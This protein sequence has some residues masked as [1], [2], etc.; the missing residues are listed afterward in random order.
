MMSQ[1]LRRLLWRKPK[2]LRLPRREQRMP[3]KR[4][5]STAI[6]MRLPSALRRWKASQ[7]TRLG[8]DATDVQSRRPRHARNC[9]RRGAA[10]DGRTRG[11]LSS[12]VGRGEV[13][14]RGRDS[15]G[16]A[17]S[18]RRR[19]GAE[20]RSARPRIHGA[21]AVPVASI[22]DAAHGGSLPG[23]AGGRAQ[24]LVRITPVDASAGD[25]ASAIVAR[26]NNDV[27]RGDFSA[28]LAGIA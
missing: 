18:V 8:A 11:A 24:N 25:D 16:A 1:R 4:P 27:A 13:A 3:R 9:R 12:G 20:R 23:K 19:R 7:I 21:D 15:V 22:R 5:R 2:L 26:I 28:A 17:R 6:S 10:R 14:R